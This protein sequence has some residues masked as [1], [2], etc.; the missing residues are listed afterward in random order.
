MPQSSMDIKHSS[1]CG[2]KQCVA[3][4]IEEI[5]NRGQFEHIND[6]LHE[7]F[8]D[9]SMPHDCFRNKKGMMLYLQQL[10]KR[11]HHQTQI[12]K[13]TAIKDFI[14]CEVRI[15]FLEIISSSQQSVEIDGYR[16][17]QMS[18]DKIIAHWEMI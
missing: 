15:Q 11:V 17:F 18:D 9:Y 3:N 10:A 16:L 5:W 14:L 4:F 1:Y 2:A 13:L 6:Y 7:H 12:L 8:V